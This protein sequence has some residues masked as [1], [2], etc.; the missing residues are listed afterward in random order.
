VRVSGIAL[1]TCATVVGSAASALTAHAVATPGV[2]STGNTG[3]VM[4]PGSVGCITSA[5]GAPGLSSAP[6]TGAAGIAG[7]SGGP[8]TAINGSSG[9]TPLV[10]HVSSKHGTTKHHSTHGAHVS[11]SASK[12]PASVC[13]GGTVNGPQP[14]PGQQPPPVVITPQPSPQPPPL[15]VQ[16]PPGLPGFGGLSG[17]TGLFG[18]LFGL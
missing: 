14:L 17:F 7:A 8:G 9:A 1:I 5:S 13:G 12:A 2:S 15:P 10:A 16:L 3:A 6:G 11:G 18:S 4:G